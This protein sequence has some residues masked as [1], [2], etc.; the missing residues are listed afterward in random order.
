[1]ALDDD[2]DGVISAENINKEAVDVKTQKIIEELLSSMEETG[3]TLDLDQ[4]TESMEN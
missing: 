2:N 1:M 3:G 4:F